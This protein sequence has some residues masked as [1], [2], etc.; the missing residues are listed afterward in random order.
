MEKLLT[1]GA[2]AGSTTR[3]WLSD[4]QIKNQDPAKSFHLDTY[5]FDSDSGTGYSGICCAGRRLRSRL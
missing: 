2:L 1:E 5:C 3:A 4:A